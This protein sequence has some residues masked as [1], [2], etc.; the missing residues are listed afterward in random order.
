MVNAPINNQEVSHE[1][2]TAFT[3]LLQMLS[4]LSEEA[5]NQVP[6]A[7]GWTAAQVGDHLSKSYNL[8]PILNGRTEPAD[9]PV[10]AKLDGIKAVFLDFSTK[11]QSPEAIVPDAGPF[12]KADLLGQ[13]TTQTQLL[14]S[15]AQHNDL[16]LV[17]LD[18]ELPKAG[19]L[20]R[21][22]WL[23]FFVVH[24]QRHIHQLK[25]IINHLGTR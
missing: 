14:I 1:L 5:L 25:K 11:L 22:E 13:L 19:T 12:E 18:Y 8:M 7:G 16:T 6:Y 3:E 2:E 24:T 17:C 20:T 10:D 15:Y 21:Y 9:R 23:Q 4:G